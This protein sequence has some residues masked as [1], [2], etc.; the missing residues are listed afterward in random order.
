MK[1]NRNN[2]QG[3]LFKENTKYIDIQTVL[4]Y[5]DLEFGSTTT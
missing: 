1:N 3:Y 5:C 2:D 4:E